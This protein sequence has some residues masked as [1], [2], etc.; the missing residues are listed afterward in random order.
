MNSTRELADVVFMNGKHVLS[1][2]P[3]LTARHI[4]HDIKRC[5]GKKFRIYSYCISSVTVE[6]RLVGSPSRVIRKVC[7]LSLVS[8]PMKLLGIADFMDLVHRPQS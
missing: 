8:T 7:R 5:T 4:H 1:G 3:I 2:T 6:G